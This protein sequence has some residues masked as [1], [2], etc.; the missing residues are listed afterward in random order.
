MTK[1]L[2]AYEMDLRLHGYNGGLN[3]SD[4]ERRQLGLAL[5]E[6]PDRNWRHLATLATSP[7]L[8]WD[9]AHA[10]IEKLIDDPETSPDYLV[11]L[12]QGYNVQT[13][14]DEAMRALETLHRK[15]LG[16]AGVNAYHLQRAGN[17]YQHRHQ[18]VMFRAWEICRSLGL[19]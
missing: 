4:E 11:E 9:V 19:D 14:E 3:L 2:T 6:H 1:T 8:G 10:A 5:L 15:Y 16:L 13:S 12:V 17:T 7:Y 18:K